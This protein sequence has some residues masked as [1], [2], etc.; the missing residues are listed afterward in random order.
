MRAAFR[1]ETEVDS[2]T[3]TTVHGLSRFDV[4]FADVPFNPDRSVWGHTNVVDVE[5][6]LVADCQDRFVRRV[7][8]SEIFNPLLE[9]EIPVETAAAVVDSFCLFHIPSAIT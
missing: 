7:L 6:E 5:P 2:V 4:E 3:P 8:L 9:R 1:V